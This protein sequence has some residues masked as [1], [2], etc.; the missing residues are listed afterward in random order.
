MRQ[1]GLDNMVV[2]HVGTAVAE[3]ADVVQTTH[4]QRHGKLEVS[5]M[6]LPLVCAAGV[7][8]GVTATGG[9]AFVCD[10][11]NQA[12]EALQVLQ[13]TACGDLKDLELGL[14]CAEPAWVVHWISRTGSADLEQQIWIGR[15]ETSGA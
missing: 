5:C 4:S 14:A 3:S 10:C 6:S 7:C 11:Q 2:M 1:R 12:Y 9:A 8:Q 13:K 15:S